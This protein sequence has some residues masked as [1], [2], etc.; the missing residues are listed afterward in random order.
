MSAIDGAADLI[1]VARQYWKFSPPAAITYGSDPA[2]DYVTAQPTPGRVIAAPLSPEMASHDPFLNGDALMAHQIRLTL[3]YHG[4]ELRRYQQLV[5]KER[6]YANLFENPNVL[7]LTNSRYLYTNAP[8]PSLT[9]LVGPAQNAA[10]TT[11]YLY[12]MPGENPAAWVT[13]IS[14]KAGD[15]AA[16]ATLLDP[17]F[18]PRR[19]TIFDTAAAIP[20]ARTDVQDLRLPDT[21]SLAVRVSTYEPGRIVLQLEGEV[22]AGAA[23]VVSEN[24][25]PG[26]RAT[27]DGVSAPIGRADYT[28]IGV[29]LP[30]GGR[31]LELAFHDPAQG[32]GKAI[33]LVSL[34]AAGAAM[35]LGL[36]LPV[37]RRA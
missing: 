14:I 7:A 21:L 15:D 19:A 32:K 27:V 9:R 28:L 23:L 36:V 8:V 26:W 25:Y 22:P 16:L 29:E 4:N 3:G 13:P 34:G 20:S 37:R 31:V 35:L 24:Y 6:G 11:V 33:T 18:D 12:Q 2:I 10:G 5:G 1:S 17:R 30:A